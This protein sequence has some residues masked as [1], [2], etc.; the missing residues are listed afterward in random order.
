MEYPASP[1]IDQRNGGLYI[2]G[3]RVMLDSVVIH[4]Q[5]GKTPP[6]IVASFPVLRLW[7]VY[8]AIAYYLE[9]EQVIREYVEEGKHEFS[10]LSAECWADPKMAA[11]RARLEAA[12]QET[13]SKPTA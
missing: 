12:R 13:S 2:A 10:R 4:Y 11:L 9:H 1:Y 3:R 5:Q 8:G 7:Q 6:E